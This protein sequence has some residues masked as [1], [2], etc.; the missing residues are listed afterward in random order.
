MNHSREHTE[1]EFLNN[2]RK[3]EIKTNNS[4]LKLEKDRKIEDRITKD[5]RNC[6]EL[7][8]KQTKK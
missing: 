3:N 8:K 7:E 4:L 5:V 6:F 1:T 2:I